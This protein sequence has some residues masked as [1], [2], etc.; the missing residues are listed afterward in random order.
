ME[1]NGFTGANC[2]FYEWIFPPSFLFVTSENGGIYEIA[3]QVTEVS[4][5]NGHKWK[6]NEV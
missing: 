1:V 4:Q 3:K 5:S 6:G 2:E